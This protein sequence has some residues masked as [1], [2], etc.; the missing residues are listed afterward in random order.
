MADPFGARLTE[1]LREL[2]PLCAGVDPSRELLARWGYS[3]NA[4]SL[5]FFAL[6]VLDAVNGVVSAIKPQ[7][8]YFE[9][10]GSPGYRVLERLIA[11]AR[12]AD[13]VVVADVKRGD[14]APTNTGYAQAWLEETSPLRVDALT[15]SPYLG[16]GALAPFF[17]LA[18][19]TDRGVFVLA[20]TSNPEGR[21]VQRARTDD[22]ERIEDMVLREVSEIN[23]SDE[24]NGSVGVVLGATRD[25]PHFDLNTLGGPFLVPGVGAQGADAS[26]VARLFSRCDDPKVLASVSRDILFE[27]PDHRALR[28][29]AQRW[30]D[31]LW[32]ALR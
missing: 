19:A 30:R 18:A 5:E 31:S 26:D 3:D 20:A 6:N 23:H 29:A 22:Q 15:V 16:V 4:D 13:V 10:F 21:I 17:E 25:A 7:V 2:G 24:G 28:D 11:D 14:F 32:N 12:D 1:R 27:G 8:A 9:R